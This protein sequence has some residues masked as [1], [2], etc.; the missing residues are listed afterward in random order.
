MIYY[1]WNGLDLFQKIERAAEYAL[2][3]NKDPNKLKILVEGGKLRDAEKWEIRELLAFMRDLDPQPF[4][5][6]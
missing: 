2:D 6:Y 1:T 4:N 5:M 3:N